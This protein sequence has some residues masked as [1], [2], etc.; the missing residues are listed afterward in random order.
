MFEFFRPVVLSALCLSALSL[1]ISPPAKADKAILLVDDREALQ[2]RVDILQQAQSEI[3][4]EYFSVWN[5]EQ[6]IAGMVLLIEAAQRG[7]KVKVIVDAL[8][9]T[10]P[11]SL[12]ATLMEKGRDKQGQK[13]LEVLVYNPLTPN[14]LAA[15]HRDHAKMIVVDG[16]RIISGGRNVGDKYFGLNKDRNFNDLDVFAEGK[17]A[18]QAREN[19]FKVWNAEQVKNVALFEFSPSELADNSCAYRLNEDNYV[20]EQRRISAIRKI[21]DEDKRLRNTLAEMVKIEDG[22]LV[23]LNTGKDWLKDSEDTISAEFV[24]QDP[25]HFNGHDFNTLTDRLAEIL[26]AAKEEANI[27]SPYLIPTAKLKVILRT[28][29]ARGVKVR[30][31]TNSLASTDNV[32]AQAGYRDAKKELIA[33][34]L[35]LYE[36]TGPNTVHA[37]TAVIDNRIALVGTYNIDPRSS[38]LNREVGIFMTESDLSKNKII[39]SLKTAIETFRA[40][41]FLVGKNKMEFNEERQNENVSTTKKTALGAVRIFLPLIKNQL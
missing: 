36:Y 38:F 14:L 5:D 25:E 10:I 12:F 11:R 3:L 18:A 40:R 28:I 1:S 16:K 4:A 27:V 39:E 32:F 24:S 35:E 15:T 21:E 20:C 30:I 22:D 33:M 8:S 41:S 29:L 6:S 7:V 31:I 9:N 17:V 13:N 26:L 37:K 2:A 23:K 34:G 19:F